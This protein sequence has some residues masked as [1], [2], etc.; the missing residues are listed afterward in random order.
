MN[1]FRILFFPDDG[2]EG[3]GGSGGADTSVLGGDS[4]GGDAGGGDG[5]GDA[6]GQASDWRSSLPEDI[7]DDPSLK[8]IAD[9]GQLAKSHIN[10]QKALGNNVA[11]P[12]KDATD[13]EWSAFFA[14]AGRPDSPA[15]YELPTVEGAE[16]LGIPEDAIN[17]LRSEAHRLGLSQRQ[18]AGL[19]QFYMKQN[20]ARLN[21]FEQSEKEQGEKGIAEL[22]QEWGTAYEEKV[23]QARSAV[24]EFGD[25]ALIQLLDDTGYGNHPTIIKAF[26]NI[27]RAMADDKL[28]GRGDETRGGH[29]MTPAEADSAINAKF[30]DSDFMNAY[31]SR[32]HPGHE[33]AVA[34]MTKLH[35]ARAG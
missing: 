4:G 8:D 7:R 22:R 2:G 29:S 28:F 15:K 26:A 11:V 23:E 31:T 14:K 35:A 24:R 10:A 16:R 21:Q 30:L 25:D 33:A 17:E 32:D 1:P 12:S 34:E 20:L 19:F 6:G 9:V 27:G 5:G 18:T 13:E 3:G